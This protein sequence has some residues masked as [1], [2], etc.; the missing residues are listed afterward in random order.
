MLDDDDF[1][2]WLANGTGY[3]ANRLKQILK[4]NRPNKRNSKFTTETY[5]EIYDF[6]IENSINSN[7]S[8][9]NMKRISK[10]D[11]MEQ[12]SNIVDPH[13]IEKKIQLKNGSKVVFTSPRMIYTE[14]VRKL[15]LSFNEKHTL[16]SLSLFF[17]Y[18]PYY[19]V[20]PTEKEK[21]SCLCINCL[22]PHLLLQS[23]NNYRKSKAF[24][25]TRFLN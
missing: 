21:S 15:H 13:L 19:C 16:V 20:R 22:N 3:K 8:F 25:I 11:F 12:Y 9:Y 24:A 10:R 17:R 2:G 4:E 5:Q 14:S 7:E 23:I 1:I 6:W 18:K